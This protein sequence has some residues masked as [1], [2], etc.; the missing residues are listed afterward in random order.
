MSVMYPE[1]LGQLEKHLDDYGRGLVRAVELD[2]RTDNH[3]VYCE[4]IATIVM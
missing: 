4:V 1:K 2:E 3:S